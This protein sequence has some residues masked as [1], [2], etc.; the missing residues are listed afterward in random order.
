MADERGRV[1]TE[2]FHARVYA[3][4][5]LVPAGAVTT[6]GDVA[7][8]LGAASVARH[9]G[10][11]LAALD[12][13]RG[14]VVPWHRVINAAGRVSA[15]GELGRP[16]LQAA[17]LA[18]EGVPIDPTGRIHPADLRRCRHRFD[19]ERVAAALAAVARSGG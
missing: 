14:R 10:W 5:A 15:R 16:T 1:V 2:G 11:A 7:S 12:E 8:A 9:V 6:Y 17:L 13:D 3:V 18:G 4:V 19:V